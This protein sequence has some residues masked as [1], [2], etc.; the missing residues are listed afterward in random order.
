MQIRHRIPT[1]QYAYVEFEEE[2]ETAEMGLMRNAELVALYNDPGL[3]SREWVAIR[4]S[5]FNTGE[6]DPNI[7]GL[8]TA[9]RYFINQCKLALR[10]I[11]K[12]EI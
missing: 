9:Q 12:E 4:R 5:M 7:Q 8:S 3:P 11:N 6:F 10:E 2:C 1:S